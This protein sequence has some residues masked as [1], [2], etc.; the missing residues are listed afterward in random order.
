MIVTGR[1]S[2]LENDSIYQTILDK[3]EFKGQIIDY[4]QICGE[5][6]TASAFGL[7]A[8]VEHLNQ[9]NA[10]SILFLNHWRN[11]DFSIIRIEKC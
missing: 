10:N 6:F 8:A 9:S 3:L 2:D 1:S 4:K 5:Y 7:Y 11:Q